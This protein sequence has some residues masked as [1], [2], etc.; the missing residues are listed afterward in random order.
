VTSER[1]AAGAP[2]TAGSGL[3]RRSRRFVLLCFCLSGAVGLA[4]QAIWFRELQG[5]F[6][7]TQQALAVVVA[8]F[9]GG[10][11]AGSWVFGPVADRH[12]RPLRLYGALEMGIGVGALLVT[13]LLWL[14]ERIYVALHPA[15]AA[16]GPGLAAV[17]A[18]LAL[19]AL[20]GPT[21]LMGGTL[22]ALAVLLRRDAGGDAAAVRRDLGR[23]YGLNTAGAVVGTAL[24][25][26]LLLERVGLRTTTLL[27]AA[28]NLGIGVACWRW[29]SVPSRAPA[30]AQPAADA[31]AG[32][33]TLRRF[34]FVAFAVSGAL[35]LAVEVAW[36]RALTQVIGSST[37][38]FSL[39][40][41]AFLLGIALGSLALQH[42]RGRAAAGVWGFGVAQIGIAAGAALV[43]PLFVRLPDLQLRAFVRVRDLD[44]VLVLQFGLCLL[45]VFLPAFAMGATFPLAA[46]AVA[47][48]RRDVGG[49]V[50]RLYAG[51]TVGG[52]VG[53]LA[54]GFVLLPHL[55]TQ[56]TLL[57]ALAGNVVL[58]AAAFVLVARR[59]RLPRLGTLAVGLVGVAAVARAI[60]TPPWDP[61]A[62]D[63]GIAV[64]GPATAQDDP[65]LRT[66]D[67]ARGSDI[68]FYREGRNANISV[69]KDETQLYLKT[70]GKTDGTSRGDMPTQLM[71]GLLPAL[72]HPAP[73]TALVIGLGTGASARAAARPPELERLDVVEIEPA[74][75]EAAQRWFGEVN[76]G[77]FTDPRV[78]VVVDDARA[79]LRTGR[80]R[81]A[82][83]VSEPS[84][85]WI[86]G[87]ANLFTVDHYRRTAARMA[88]DGVMAQWLQIYAMKPELVQ[89]V[90]ASMQAVFPHLQ[91]WSFRYGDLIVLAS[92][93]P[94]PAFD[95]ARTDAR[96]DAWGVRGQV[97]E[98]LAC[99]T[100]AGLLG[101][102]TLAE[103]DVTAFAAGAAL[104][105]DD[106]PRLEFAAPRSLYLATRDSNASLL[107]SVRR[108]DLPPLASGWTPTGT[109]ALDIARTA[110]AARRSIDA[111]RW[112]AR[113]DADS[114]TPRAE[115]ELEAGRQALAAVHM[116]RANQALRSAW[117]RAPESIV[118]AQEFARLRFTQ[119]YVAETA[120]LLARACAPEALR[121]RDTA[122]A[123]IDLLEATIGRGES[124]I[125]APV[126]EQLLAAAGAAALDATPHARLWALTAGLALER[127]DLEGA[128]RG[129]ERALAL[130]PQCTLAWRV[131]GTVA[132]EA[133]RWPEAIQWWERLVEYRQLSPDLLTAL[134]NAYERAGRVDDARRTVRRALREE[135]RHLPAQR[136]RE[137]LGA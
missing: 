80:E 66:R 41:C 88:D 8:A 120:E 91:V 3:D 62:L 89:M 107:E 5:L 87:V 39:I 102:F 73:R 100:A 9:M 64:G 76:T 96:L 84:N 54:A 27:A 118:V 137:R 77:L 75:V 104:N 82:F 126:I 51:N 71:L 25:G 24:V 49:A 40:L 59:A 130:N 65:E 17:R 112:L 38:A 98:V 53:A 36:T 113:A 81:Y 117:Q 20:L 132:Y 85:P 1:G 22:P 133:Q 52:I 60:T 97:R 55:G 128:R 103:E 26:F 92:R 14:V 12:A 90:L 123:A 2:R 78:H 122:D 61:Y 34:I 101:F 7:V 23:L 94:L 135:P 106:R 72:V 18:V 13:P 110:R 10:L 129:A 116:D 56:R 35:A 57:W 109:E 121:R 131:L 31:A 33:A 29:R 63:A 108:A 30:A 21:V 134:A 99:E 6:G 105:T 74:V 127:P 111:Q 32:D 47:G 67:V 11:A 19:V 70:N 43:L 95:V 93:A 28:A 42:V 119:G 58:A 50:G 46:G 69:R 83:V 68:L 44:A 114:T 15:L 48:G 86:A 37:Y 45:V 124:A 79:F 136:L 115:W 125:A 4:Y 16:S